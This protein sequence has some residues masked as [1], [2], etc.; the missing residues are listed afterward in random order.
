[1]QSLGFLYRQLQSDECD[2]VWYEVNVKKGSKTAKELRTL[3]T[4]ADFK[5]IPEEDRV[6]PDCSHDVAVVIILLYVE[7]T[8]VRSNCQ[9]LV[10]QFHADVR[11]EGRIDLNFTGNLSWLLGVR[12]SHGEDGSVS[13]DQ[14][15]YIEAMAETWLLEGR[16]AANVKS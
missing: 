1:M 16:E 10:Q 15:H 7:N 6:Y 11:T 9:T 14:Q 4:L 2:L 12:Y 8:G 3:T 13:C 5:V